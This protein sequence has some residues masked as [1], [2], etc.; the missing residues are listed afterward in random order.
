MK[1][2]KEFTMKQWFMFLVAVVYVILALV[3]LV[4]IRGSKPSAS[5]LNNAN[6]ALSGILYMSTFII[7]MVI[8]GHSGSVKEKWTLAELLLA[9]AGLVMFILA[10]VAISSIKKAAASS[11]DNTIKSKISTAKKSLYGMMILGSMLAFAEALQRGQ[12]YGVGRSG[13]NLLSPSPSPV[14]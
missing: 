5:N 6:R 9:S 11:D 10:A 14:A 2:L 12:K 8:G 3:V 1:F 13:V 7:G 4:S